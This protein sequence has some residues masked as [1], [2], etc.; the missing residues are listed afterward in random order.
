M[1]EGQNI[2]DIIKNKFKEA[3]KNVGKAMLKK[4]KFLTPYIAMGI[5]ILLIASLILCLFI[6]FGEVGK[7]A[8]IDDMSD[9]VLSGKIE[10]FLKDMEN[11]SLRKYMQDPNSISYSSVQQYVTA[12]RTKYKM[13]YT[14]FDG[15]LN[16]SYGIMVRNRNGVPNNEAY[17]TEEN[18]NLRDLLSRYDSGEEILVDVNILDRIFQKI[19]NNKKTNLTNVLESNNAQMK[20]NEI[21]ALVSVCYQYGNCGQY[22]AG[23]RNIANIYNT[24]YKSGNSE[25]FKQNAVCQ[26]SAGGFSNFFVT[27]KYKQRE[28][29]IWEMFSE[30]IYRYSDGT[31]IIVSSGGTILECAKNI[32]SYME[33]KQYEYCIKN[34]SGCE[35]NVNGCGLN[36][37]FEASK[38]GYHNTCCATYVSW[39][40]I[41]AGYIKESEMSH[42]ATRLA[43]ILEAK[44][45]KRVSSNNLQAGDIMFYD[46]GHIEIYAGD[47]KVYNAGSK[48]AIQKASP[49]PVY[50]TPT[51]GLR[52][53]Y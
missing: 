7:A 37:T 44:G 48:S 41:D 52:P 16:F 53:P 8:T 30:G 15:C 35:H 24:Y 5:G 26:N 51:Y 14:E 6:D 33:E 43:N 36:S 4:L 38:S 2:G 18:I 39:V 47:N 42:S 23:E 34:R 27:G 13:Y 21:D 10:E 29:L 3:G 19:V 25:G 45:F 28:K 31:E 40:L 49:S 22:I 12:D 32:H 11:S 46:Y 9:V 50:A 1:G 17:F 20:E